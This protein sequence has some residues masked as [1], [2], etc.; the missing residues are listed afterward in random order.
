MESEF[1]SILEA[2]KLLNIKKPTMYKLAKSGK[3]NFKK[4]GKLWRIK[5]EDIEKLF[6]QSEGL[7]P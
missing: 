4:V 7:E 5:R 1:M 2:S 3:L 6:M